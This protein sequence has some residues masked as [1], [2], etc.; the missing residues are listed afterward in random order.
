MRDAMKAAD[1]AGRFSR[2]GFDEISLRSEYHKIPY[3]KPSENIM[4]VTTELEYLCD[5]KNTSSVLNQIE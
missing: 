5:G 2:I 4:V 1:E 3:R